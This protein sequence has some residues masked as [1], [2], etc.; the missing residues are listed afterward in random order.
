MNTIKLIPTAI[1]TLI[2]VSMKK[3]SVAYDNLIQHIIDNKDKIS[4]TIG[5]DDRFLGIPKSYIM[6]VVLENQ[7]EYNIEIF[8]NMFNMTGIKQLDTYNVTLRNNVKSFNIE[9]ERPGFKMIRTFLKDIVEPEVDKYIKKE[10]EQS[11]QTYFNNIW[12]NV[13]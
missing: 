3:H 2:K 9:D 4:F 8:P 7:D 11:D 10:N 13:K 5:Q 6:T 1:S 12:S